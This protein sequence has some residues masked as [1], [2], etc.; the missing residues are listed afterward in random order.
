MAGKK[1]SPR[2][3]YIRQCRVNRTLCL[4]AIA[5]AKEEGKRPGIPRLAAKFGVTVQC[6]Y[7]WLREDTLKRA[8][9]ARLAREGGE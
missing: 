1:L 8:V 9:D 6:V 7:K 3:A 4:K 5:K 2:V